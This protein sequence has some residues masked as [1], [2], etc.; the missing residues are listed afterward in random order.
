MD[1]WSYGFKGKKHYYFAFF[2]HH[3]TAPIKRWKF[4][5]DQVVN[6]IIFAGKGF[7]VVRCQPF[8][9]QNLRIRAQTD[10][11]RLIPIQNIQDFQKL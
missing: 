4:L 1:Y 6:G 8:V 10:F 3:S 5:Y 2:I 7:F 11:F 9:K